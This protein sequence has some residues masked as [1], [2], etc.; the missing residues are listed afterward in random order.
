M[1]P[2]K[3][4]LFGKRSVNGELAVPYCSHDKLYKWQEEKYTIH[5]L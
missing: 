4:A 3:K 1:A 2:F 5:R